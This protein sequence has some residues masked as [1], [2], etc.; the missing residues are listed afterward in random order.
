MACDLNVIIN[1]ITGDCSNSSLGAFD[2]SIV[3]D[4]PDYS[5]QWIEPPLGTIAL[6]PGVTGYSINS[7]SAGTYTLNVLDSCPLENTVYL[8]NIN[9][10]SGT[11]VSIESSGTTCGLNN[12]LIT[13]STTN[14][15]AQASYILYETTN[16]YVTSG[17]TPITNF[18]FGSLSAGTYYVIADDGGG[19]TGKSQSCII[20]P[21]NPFTFG[22]YQ[23]NNSPCFINT[24]ALYITGLTGNPPYTYSWSNGGIGQSIT[25][26]SNGN[27]S[28]VVTDGLG[29]N[30]V[31][32]ATIESVPSIG[33]LILIDSEPTCYSS[34]GVATVYI[35]GGTGPY[36]IEGSNGDVIITFDTSYTFTGLSSGFFSVTVTDAGLC[37]STITTTLQTPSGLSLVSVD[38]TNSTCNNNGGGI[39]VSIFG[40][41]SPYLYT[42][43]DSLSNSTT[44]IQ[45]V[46]NG[47]ANFLGLSSGTYL[48]TI[49]DNLGICPYSQYVTVNNTVLYTLSVSTTGTTCG[50]DNGSVTLS[51][52]TGG[53]GPYNY[54]INGQTVISNTLSYTFTNL[55]SGSYTASVT[56]INLC[57]QISP[58][59]INSSQ[60]VNFI[61]N[62][63]SPVGNNGIVET[64]I[65]SGEPP[66]TL[67][68]S[69]I[70]KKGLKQMLLEGFFDLT[71]GDTNCILNSSIFEAVVSVDGI[72]QTGI[73]YSGT[74]VNDFPTDSVFFDTVENLL[75]NYPNIETVI[76]DPV[77]GNLKIST[78]CNPPI[79]IMDAT[80]IIDVKVYYNISCE[81]C[82]PPVNTETIIRINTTLI[83]SGSTPTDKFQL[84]TTLAGTYNF[85]VDWGDGVVET[86][87]TWN[88]PKTEHTYA[89]GGVKE[90]RISGQFSGWTFNNAGDRNKLIEIK[91]WGILE[92]GDTP[93]HFYGC[94][95]LVL[96]G[97]TDFIN[98]STTSTLE[99]TFR[100]CT[101][102][103]TINN[104]EYWDTSN[105]TSFVNTFN[106]TVFNQDITSWEVSGV[107]D[108]SFMFFNNTSFNQDIGSWNVS[109]FNQDIGS[110]NVSNVVDMSGMFYNATSFNQDIGGWDVSNVTNMNV[111]FFNAT[112][113]NQD[114]GLWDVSSVTNM[115]GMFEDATSFNQDIGLWDV[116]NV[117]NM[118]GMFSNA[119]SFNQDIGSWNV[120]NVT[121]MDSMFSNATSF[122]QD[123]GLWDVS[124]VTNMSFMFFNNASFNQDIG[125][126]DVSN[127]TDMSGMFLNTTSFNQD[128]GSWNV[129][130]VTDMTGMF[131]DATSF[132]QD[133]GLWDVSNVT[134]MV[135]MLRDC[136]MNQ[137]NYENLLIGW[138]SLPS[139]QIAVNLGALGRQYQIGSASDIAR[140]NIIASYSWTITGDIAVP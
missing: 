14:L 29:C 34:D 5:I 87:T 92:L 16:G 45:P 54:Q 106:G 130:N 80:V 78:L 4:A 56:D 124:N 41:T 128:I 82:A 28:V 101:S 9:I 3:G 117:T 46:Q 27:Y 20:K 59:T 66:F 64:F 89:T 63:T 50:N 109:T 31:A 47:G 15:Y 131:Q 67:N 103:T 76:I 123:I 137:T 94:N 17:T 107:T 114:I 108:M 70:I 126:W 77:T 133:I 140:S 22:L 73:F 61:L 68:W 7:L 65:T 44:F 49:D 86:I 88:D 121:N 43:T 36:H 120:L 111:M 18:V 100:D 42:L 32:T 12:G 93:G 136:G 51:I 60:S 1:G 135:S 69:Q 119:T 134:S 13:A 102:L 99:N 75:L 95:N 55:P 96:T 97:V 74:G 25:G 40:G 83:S 26:L 23:V 110:W 52:T 91:Q 48:L 2:I 19:C 85:D 62:G 129:S 53:T 81:V 105:I 57:Q 37:Q 132:N 33:T 104:V 35:T 30:A 98:L 58:F 79:T 11:C 8:F 118:A 21:S 38:V 116:S 138:D 122:N 72:V 127:V 112:S 6:G 71:S 113:F 39:L 90:I 84:A 125:L 24:G 139:L 10:S 115:A